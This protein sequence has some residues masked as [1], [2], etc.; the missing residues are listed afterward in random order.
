M[1][2]F[3]KKK[4]KERERRV[5][6]FHPRREKKGRMPLFGFVDEGTRKKESPQARMSCKKTDGQK[7][8]LGDSLGWN[9]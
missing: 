4:K 8:K 5:R 2:R 3:K 9:R 6:P 7:K 1:R